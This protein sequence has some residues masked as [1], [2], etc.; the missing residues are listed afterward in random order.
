MLEMLLADLLMKPLIEIKDTHRLCRSLL[1]ATPTAIDLA[2][3]NTLFDCDSAVV[4]PL[5]CKVRL[6]ATN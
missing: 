2:L 4:R 3:L 5:H 6:S 1:F